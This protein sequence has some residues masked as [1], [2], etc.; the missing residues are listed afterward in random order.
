MPTMDPS[1]ETPTPTV[2]GPTP[3]AVLARIAAA[4]G[5]WFPSEYAREAGI[6]R[7]RLNDPLNDLRNAGLVIVVDWVKGKGQGYGPTPDGE[8]AAAD[9]AALAQALAFDHPPP[10]PADVPVAHPDLPPAETRDP[11][12][13]TTFDRGELARQALFSPPPPVVT[14]ILILANLA[15]FAAGVAAAWRA[16][17]GVATYL[18]GWDNNTLMRLGGVSGDALLNWEVWR[19]GT[20]CFVHAGGLH[21]LLNL[22]ALGVIGPVAEG[23]WGRWRFALIY[24]WA[25]LAGSCLAMALRPEGLVVGAS[26]AVWGVM[27][28]VLAWLVL[29]REYLPPE[30]VLDWLR[31][32]ALVL[33]VNIVVSFA[34]R[35]SWEAHLGGA[36]VGF[37]AAVLANVV[38]PGVVRPWVLRPAAVALGLIPVGCLAALAV[39]SVVGEPW[40][41]VRDRAV[42]RL[43]RPIPYEQVKAAYDDAVVWAVTGKGPKGLPGRVRDLR[44]EA[45]AAVTGIDRVDWPGAPHEPAAGYAAA[46]ADLM[47]ALAEALAAPTPPPASAWE[48]VAAKMKAV[49]ELRPELAPR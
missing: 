15:W 36:A 34:P 6:D 13:L 49:K 7:D 12:G 37:A 40:R 21:L 22:Y 47:A 25:G 29:N 39:Y 18:R 8:K 17:G 45:A 41:A 2:V 30:V 26:G 27:A 46:V 35:V 16:G 28:A 33:A 38:R 5:P 24:A 1:D 48:A 4:G 10:P 43:L 14:P 31:T 42:A 44:D 3:A 9:P 11:G 20:A 32:L 19:L 23:L